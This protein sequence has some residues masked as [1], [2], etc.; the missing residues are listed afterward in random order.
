MKL[1]GFE[2]SCWDSK[3]AIINQQGIQ[4]YLQYYVNQKF[5]PLLSTLHS[6]LSTFL[7][8]TIISYLRA[9]RL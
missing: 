4:Q 8:L 3:K 1:Q 2:P 5:Y 9:F 6:L 7:C